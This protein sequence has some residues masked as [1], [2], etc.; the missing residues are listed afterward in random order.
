MLCIYKDFLETI[1]YF[2]AFFSI[3][4]DIDLLHNNAFHFFQVNEY[5]R[6]LS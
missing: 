3:G 4:F 1:A 2:F 5:N 6:L